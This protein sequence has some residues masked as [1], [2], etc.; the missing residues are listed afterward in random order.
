MAIAS[1][2][3]AAWWSPKLNTLDEIVSDN[4]DLNQCINI[5]LR[6][7]KGSRPHK[8]E[9][10]SDLWTYIDQ[11]VTI[12]TPQ[13]VR[14]VYEAVTRWEPRVSIDRVIVLPAVTELWHLQVKIYWNLVDDLVQFQGLAE[15]N[16]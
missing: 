15:V 13:I 6:T 1:E 5:I 8:P 4:D 16:L 14:E 11:P 9:F 2:I 10:G 7:P 3:T 12:A